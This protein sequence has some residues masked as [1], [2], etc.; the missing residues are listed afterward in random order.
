MQ[1]LVKLFRPASL[2]APAA[3]VA[4]FTRDFRMVLNCHAERRL[5]LET[6]APHLATWL[7]IAVPLDRWILWPPPFGYPPAALG[8]LGLF[9]LF[10]RFYDALGGFAS[11][12]SHT[13]SKVTRPL[14]PPFVYD[15]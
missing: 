11:P 9:A 5:L 15:S 1:A 2:L 14:A 4:E 12:P 10:F 3:S 6:T 7:P 13:I 8:P